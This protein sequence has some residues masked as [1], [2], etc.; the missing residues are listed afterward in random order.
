MTPRPHPRALPP[1]LPLAGLNPV[2]EAE[3]DALAA[4]E[5]LAWKE[6]A[7]QSLV[8]GS[9]KLPD[10]ADTFAARLAAVLARLEL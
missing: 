9:A 1:S 8:V 6:A 10:P 4:R 7:P 3:I 2:E 5:A